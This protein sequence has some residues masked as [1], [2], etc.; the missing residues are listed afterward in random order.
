[1]MGQ[2][3]IGRRALRLRLQMHAK[4]LT[5]VM[6]NMLLMVLQSMRSLTVKLLVGL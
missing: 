1:M 6:K 3:N 5:S 2:S 4:L